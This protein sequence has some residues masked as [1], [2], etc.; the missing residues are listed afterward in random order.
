MAEETAKDSGTKSSSSN[1]ISSM[2]MAAV[3]FLRGKPAWVLGMYIAARRFLYIAVPVI[4]WCI[5]LLFEKSLPSTLVFGFT[6]VT[7]VA[8]FLLSI[9]LSLLYRAD[10]LLAEV[11][12]FSGDSKSF[13]LL[14]S[15]FYVFV[16]FMIIGAISGLLKAL[17]GK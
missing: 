15:L 14:V 4:I 10:L 16:N 5:A 13:A 3:E 11:M 7:T 12:S 1:K 8:L 2:Q 17:R 9:P 6:I